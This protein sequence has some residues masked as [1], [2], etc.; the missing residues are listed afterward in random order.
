MGNLRRMRG[1]VTEI[2]AYEEEIRENF[3]LQFG[4]KCFGEG[5]YYS[6]VQKWKES[7]K[8]LKEVEIIH[9]SICHII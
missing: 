4:E 8:T 6:T 7:G 1:P 9:L 3:L 2:E 5:E